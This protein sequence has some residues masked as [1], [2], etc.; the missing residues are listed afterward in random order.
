MEYINNN[1]IIL[2]FILKDIKRKLSNFKN[3]FT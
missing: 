2:K 1:G 3:Y